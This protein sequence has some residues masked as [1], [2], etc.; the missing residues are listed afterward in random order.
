MTPST[1]AILRI[2]STPRILAWAKFLYIW[3]E[4][5]NQWDLWNQITSAVSTS[6]HIWVSFLEPAKKT[7]TTLRV[8]TTTN[9]YALYAFDLAEDI[10]FNLAKQGNSS[11]EQVCRTLWPSSLTQSLVALSILTATETSYKTLTVKHEHDVNVWLLDKSV[12][13][14]ISHGH[15][16]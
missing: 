12:N 9:G 7:V 10:H 16:V 6:K 5:L 15:V 11:L 14:P 8:K 4:T 1:D 3:M 13:L 2:H